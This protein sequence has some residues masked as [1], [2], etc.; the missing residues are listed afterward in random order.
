M[1]PVSARKNLSILS[2]CLAITNSASSHKEALVVSTKIIIPNRSSLTPNNS[3]M[4]AWLAAPPIQLPATAEK[5]RHKVSSINISGEIHLA[6]PRLIG[7]LMMIAIL[8][9]KNIAMAFQPRPNIFGT[10]IDKVIS[11]KL[12][13]N[14]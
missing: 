2:L 4:A 14:R 6:I 3:F 5:P 10:S 9:A 8:A 1:L 13:G 7:P 11:S 12:A